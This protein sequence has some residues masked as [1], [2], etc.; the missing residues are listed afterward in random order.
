MVLD[1]DSIA[2]SCRVI[3]SAVTSA[4]WLWEFPSPDVLGCDQGFTPPW[5]ASGKG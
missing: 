4:S 3:T 2:S 1:E 5:L